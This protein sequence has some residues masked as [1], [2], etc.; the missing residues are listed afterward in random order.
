MEQHPYNDDE[1]DRYLSDEM[2]AQEK[3]AF[4]QQLGSDTSLADD[5]ALQRDTI[6]GI[7]LDG[8]QDLKKQLQAIEAGLKKTT[9]TKEGGTRRLM[10]WIA[11]AASIL[12]VVLVGYLFIPTATDPESL[13][14]AYY[15]PYPNLI[16]PAQRS[17]EVDEETVLEQAVRAYENQDYERALGLFE[18]GG[19]LSNAGFTFYYAASYLGIDKPQSAIPLFEQ[20]IQDESNLFYGPSL[21]YSALAHLKMD[22]KKAAVP[23]LEKLATLDGD[24]ST[25]A[26]ELLDDIR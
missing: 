11:I 7:R 1:L 5:L 16:N 21:W 22:N 8:S 10:S 12:A 2:N 9:A 24:Y 19:G 6:A 14:V 20:V 3:Q 18:Q 26:Q 23:L 13:Y 17:V 4:E 25:E 15:Q